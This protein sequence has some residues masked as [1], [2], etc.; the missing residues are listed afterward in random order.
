[1][2]ETGDRKRGHRI[3]FAVQQYIGKLGHTANGVVSVTS[4]GADGTRHIPL[5]VRPYIPAARL[6]RGK[7]DAAFRTKPELA[8]ELIQEARAA[9]VPFHVV[10]ASVNSAG[11]P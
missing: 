10:V 3:P 4:H 1:M 5:G 11:D 7:T 6:P 2:D 9:N 8:W